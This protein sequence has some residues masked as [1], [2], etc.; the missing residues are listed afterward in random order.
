MLWTFVLIV[1]QI[2]E[3][4]TRTVYKWQ[5]STVCKR[6]SVCLHISVFAVK[7]GR[8]VLVGVHIM[9]KHNVS[10]HCF[11]SHYIC[12]VMFVWNENESTLTVSHNL[13]TDRESCGP[14]C[15]FM[16]SYLEVRPTLQIH[17]S[18]IKLINV[19]PYLDCSMA[20]QAFHIQYLFS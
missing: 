1:T 2:P 14:L 12:F 4:G 17:I 11:N 15:P 19:M 7:D 9:N 6:E 10:K 13:Q 3:Y 16:G 8:L 5:Q 20:L 18:L